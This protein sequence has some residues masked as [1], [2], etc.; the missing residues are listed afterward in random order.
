MEEK[1]NEYKSCNLC[2]RKCGVDRYEQKGYCR[3]LNTLHVARAALHMWEEPCISGTRGSGT[4]FFSGCN[5]GCVFCQNRKISRGEVGKKIDI[6]RLT[7]IFFELEA[8]GANNINLVTGD[9][10]IPSIRIAID[11]AKKDG[12]KIP[13]LLNTSSYLTV[14]TVKSL[15]GLID[16]YLPD[17]KYIRDEDA[18]RYS[19]APGYVDAAKAAIDEMVR[20]CPCCE[21]EKEYATADYSKSLEASDDRSNRQNNDIMKK[22]VVVRHLLMPGMLIQAKLIIKYL[23]HKYVDN[24]YLSLLNQ[25]TPN[26][27]LGQFPEIDR[28]VTGY[29]YH[30]LTSYAENLGIKN[31]F[32]QVGETANESFIPEFDCQGV[33]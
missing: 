6:K 16:I 1:R 29:E 17:F 22:G 7:E 10:F 19:N 14:D 23:Y 4:V 30:S 32:I 33:L 5:M 27:E 25:F 12:L 15:E 26:G 28:K 18:I 3:E 11:L 8:K 31:C 2:P 24:I 20:Q 21:F 13:F 9:M